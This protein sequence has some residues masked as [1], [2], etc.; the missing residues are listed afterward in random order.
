MLKQINIQ[1]FAII[2]KTSIDFN[3][4]LTVITG[5]TGAGKSIVID[6][7][8]QLLGARAS[9]NMVATNNDYAL[10]EGIFDYN[11]QIEQILQDNDFVLEDD[12][13]VISKKIK[14]DGKSQ[15]KLNNRLITNDIIKQI[16]KHL[17]EIHSQHATYLLSEQVSQQQYIDG[18]FN[19]DEK[20][21]YQE[22]ILEYNNYQNLNSGKKKENKTYSHPASTGNKRR[23]VLEAIK[24]ANPI[25]SQ[26][27]GKKGEN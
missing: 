12:Y 25:S 20:K 14:S 7:I 18:L 15:L 3:E 4:H 11:E 22:Y 13:L 24:F 2:E 5:Q 8:E 9:Q 21:I 17:V 27:Q 10:I 26:G 23:A 1:N 16:S 19:L 6:A